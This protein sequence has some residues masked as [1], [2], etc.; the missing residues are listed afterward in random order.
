[1]AKVPLKLE[2]LI[3]GAALHSAL[4]QLAAGEDA[5]APTTRAAVLQ[6]LKERIGS[7][8]QIAERLLM[9]DGSGIACAQRLSHLMDEIIRALCDFAI[10]HVH[11]PKG[12]SAAERMA[13]VAVGGYGRGTLAPGSDIDLL[14]LLPVQ[15]DALG[16]S[17]IVEYML[18]MLW[19]LG[20][21]V[22]HATRNVDEC[23]RLSRAD[24]TIRTA[25]LEAR[26]LWGEQK[27]YAEPCSTASTRRWSRTPAPN[28]PR[29][30]S[31][32]ATSAT[33]RPAKAAIWS[34]PTSRTAKAAC[35]TCRRCSGSASI[36][37]A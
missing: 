12:R 26:F 22:G 7:G 23:L 28:T 6:L 18:Y 3:D 33:A 9:E 17:D 27:L 1:M 25:I 30:S 16:R 20:L 24:M 14:F 31:P 21:K 2:Q 35:A 4:E 5:G 32:S 8:R 10:T 29:P 13:L 36:S 37:T 34:S 19:D 11:R 15:A